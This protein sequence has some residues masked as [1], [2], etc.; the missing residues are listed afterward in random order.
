MKLEAMGCSYN[1]N[2]WGNVLC[3][4]SENSKCWL[5]ECESCR[6]GKKLVPTK[7]LNFETVADSGNMFTYQIISWKKDLRRVRNHLRNL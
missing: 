1:N 5:S 7:P 6:N 4:V 2:F 3:D